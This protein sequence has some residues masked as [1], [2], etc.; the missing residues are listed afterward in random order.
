MSMAKPRDVR[1]DTTGNVGY[2]PGLNAIWW[3]RSSSEQTMTA[4][5]TPK[6][7]KGKS[8]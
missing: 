5:F 7:K 6:E 2:Y 4:P 1:T 8:K 3:H